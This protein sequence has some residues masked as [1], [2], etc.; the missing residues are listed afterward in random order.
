MDSECRF[1]AD[2]SQ[3]LISSIS[4]ANQWSPDQRNG[5]IRIA[6]SPVNMQY[7]LADFNSEVC[8]DL[9]NAFCHLLKRVLI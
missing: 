1:S 5:I 2:N 3:M 9:V 8:V 4:T 7:I 6:N